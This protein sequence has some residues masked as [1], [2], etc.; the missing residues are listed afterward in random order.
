MK[1]N[2]DRLP[3][4]EELPLKLR[5]LYER[6]GYARYRMGKFEPYDLYME[7]KQFLKSEGII[8]F[9]DATGRL[10]ALKPDVTMSIVK[11]VGA[12]DGSRKYY[13]NE[14]VFRIEQGGREYREIR[15][16]GVEYIGADTAY[17]EA[18][19]VKLAVDT[20]SEI[21]AEYTLDISHMGFISGLLIALG[22]EGEAADETLAALKRKDAGTLARIA[23]E[24]SLGLREKDAFTALARFRQPLGEAVGALTG[25]ALSPEMED[26]AAELAVLSET[27][28]A[29]GCAEGVHVDFSVINGLDYYNGLVYRGYV[30][31]APRAVLAGGR[32]DNLLRRFGKPQG[33]AGFAL[34]LGELDRMLYE[35]REY[36]ADVLLVYG[37][38]SPARVALEAARIAGGGE[39]VRAEREDTGE[40]K[41]K[42][43][44][45]VIC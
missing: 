45:A 21:S 33:A 9:T 44:E 12:D 19:V 3:K 5:S 27:L 31:E 29:F 8:T 13:Y 32:Y 2:I 39:S 16:M 23:G 7:N 34:Y 42:R 30:R 18:E 15:Q 24:R 35:P 10:M 28:T 36:D 40:V 17:A 6:Y 20:L 25:L 4:E 38:A 26:A 11:N 41:A 43:V 1:L 14:N 22:I 37:G